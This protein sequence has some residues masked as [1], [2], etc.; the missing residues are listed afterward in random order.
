MY[1]LDI[2]FPSS[3]CNNVGNAIC[4]FGYGCFKNSDLYS[5]SR[6][7]CPP[8]WLCET[9]VVEL[10]EQCGGEDYVGVTRSAPGLGCYARS[11]W[12]SHCATSCPGHT[13]GYAKVQNKITHTFFV[14]LIKTKNAK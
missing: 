5:E 6:P 8:T 13:T 4:P 10:N 3:T 9:D 2:C 7:Y 12:C 1:R 14:C 11:K